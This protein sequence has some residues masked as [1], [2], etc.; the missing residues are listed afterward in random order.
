MPH[1]CH[2]LCIEITQI[3]RFK[4]LAIIEQAIHIRDVLG[5]EVCETFN[6]CE[7][8]H[9][10]KHHTHC[11]H[12]RII[13]ERVVKLHGSYLVTIFICIP[14]ELIRFPFITLYIE[15]CACSCLTFVVVAEGKNIIFIEEC[16]SIFMLRI[17][18]ALNSYNSLLLVIIILKCT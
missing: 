7:I 4:F 13:S 15:Y 1:L 8:Y 9:I 18:L 2:I 16:I 11:R 5:I 12:E 6:R 10:C 3:E 17:T 14:I